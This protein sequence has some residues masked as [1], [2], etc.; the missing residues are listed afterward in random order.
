M[1]QKV[2]KQPKREKKSKYSS[3]LNFV[4][5]RFLDFFEEKLE[6]FQKMNSLD[7]M[8]TQKEIFEFNNCVNLD[9]VEKSRV[10][11]KQ[12]EEIEIYKEE[13]ER[14]KMKYISFINASSFKS[15]IDLQNKGSEY[16]QKSI[17]IIISN[18]S[19]FFF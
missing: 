8:K 12:I 13:L 7:L 10:V 17:I 5:E 6:S 19:F 1:I 3:L 2:R 16:S 14:N 11:N 4:F 18:F 15:L 9:L